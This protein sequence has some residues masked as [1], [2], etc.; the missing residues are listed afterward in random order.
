MTPNS[1]KGLRCFNANDA[2]VWRT[3][4]FGLEAAQ[5]RQQF[6]EVGGGFNQG[7]HGAVGLAEHF[8]RIFCV[9]LERAAELGPDVAVFD[10]PEVSVYRAAPAELVEAESPRFHF[11]AEVG[12]RA[13]HD[14]QRGVQLVVECGAEFADALIL[15]QHFAHFVL[16]GRNKLL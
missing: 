16:P 4:F 2:L 10:A 14:V 9:A 3:E 11:G 12:R 15:A 5:F 13:L 6:A 8:F 7:R 1:R